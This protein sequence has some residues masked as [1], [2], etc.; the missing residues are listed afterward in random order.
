MHASFPFHTGAVR[1]VRETA[2][3]RA[4]PLPGKD[5]RAAVIEVQWE[6]PE[7]RMEQIP[8]IE[9]QPAFDRAASGGHAFPSGGL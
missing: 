4:T 2:M 7:E 8:A 6:F 9:T 1:S 3:L 5:G